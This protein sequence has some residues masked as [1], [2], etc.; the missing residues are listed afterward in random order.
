MAEKAVDVSIAALAIYGAGSWRAVTPSDTVP[1]DPGCRGLYI[2]ASGT[3]TI[4]GVWDSTAASLG[5]PAANVLIPGRFAFV[6]STGTS[7]TVLALYQ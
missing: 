3:L 7:A 1:L 4:K 2:T 5:T 6:M